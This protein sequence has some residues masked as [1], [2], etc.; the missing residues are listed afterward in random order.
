[1]L[2]EPS[3]PVRGDL[4]EVCWVDI[5]EDSIGD[6]DKA[7]LCKRISYALFWNKTLSEGVDC[8]VTTATIDHDASTQQ[9]YC[10]YP[11][12]CVLSMK[13]IKRASRARRKK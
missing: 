5:Y 3:D 11:S 9:G 2:I 6:P 7:R 1:V 13:V 8:V 4:V 10:I 12:A